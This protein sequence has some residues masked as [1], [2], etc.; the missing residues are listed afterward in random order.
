MARYTRFAP[1]GAGYIVGIT[2]EATNGE[3]H[4][5]HRSPGKGHV[6]RRS[7]K[8]EEGYEFMFMKII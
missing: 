8:G 7:D 6:S 5:F 1:R 4:L 3:T 2:S